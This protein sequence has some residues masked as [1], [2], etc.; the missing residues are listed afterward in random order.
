MRVLQTLIFIKSPA[1]KVLL[2]RKKRKFGEGTLNGYG[3][4]LQGNEDIFAC[5]IRELEE[6]SGLKVCRDDLKYLGVVTFH[7]VLV[8]S[9]SRAVHIFTITDFSEDPIESEEMEKGVWFDFDAIPYKKMLPDARYWLPLVLE[10]RYLEAKFDYCDGEIV[11][12]EIRSLNYP[13][14]NMAGGRSGNLS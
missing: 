11:T 10:D 7:D 3:G 9:R 5:A 4:K 8:G 2:A 6:E 1:G 12:M 14:N 13:P